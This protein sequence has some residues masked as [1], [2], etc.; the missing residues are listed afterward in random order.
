MLEF[1]SVRN[2]EHETTMRPIVSRSSNQEIFCNISFQNMLTFVLFV[3]KIQYLIQLT[4]EE[5]TYFD[6]D[7]QVLQADIKCRTMQ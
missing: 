5:G 4:E 6:M 7:H 3:V 1:G 2:Q